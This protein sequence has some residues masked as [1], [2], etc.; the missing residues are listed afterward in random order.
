[1]PGKS[2]KSFFYTPRQPSL[3]AAEADGG[4]CLSQTGLELLA[5]LGRKW[6]SGAFCLTTLRAVRKEKENPTAFDA[7]HGILFALTVWA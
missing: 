2:A 5:I 3:P 7:P 6:S 1:L 4:R